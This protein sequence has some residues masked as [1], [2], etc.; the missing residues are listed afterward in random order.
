MG[1]DTL[2]IQNYL[3]HAYIM[4]ASYAACV[5]CVIYKLAFIVRQTSAMTGRASAFLRL[6]ALGVAGAMAYKGLTRFE[7]GDVAQ[8]PDIARELSLCVFLAAAIVAFRQKLGH[9]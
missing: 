5:I 1:N 4:N 7:H 2:A 6:A 3:S 9:W 8:W